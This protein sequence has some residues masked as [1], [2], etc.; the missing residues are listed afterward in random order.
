M[1]SV[2]IYELMSPSCVPCKILKPRLE[3]IKKD[4]PEVEVV[5]IDLTKYLN[6]SDE[7]INNDKDLPK[8]IREEIGEIRSTPHLFVLEGDKVLLNKHGDARVL[9]EIKEICKN[10]FTK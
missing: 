1:N 3:D 4:Y 10:H 7:D 8:G 6:M 2:R 9:I 5:Y